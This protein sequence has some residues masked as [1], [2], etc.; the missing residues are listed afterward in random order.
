MFLYYINLVFVRI[1]SQ[2]IALS[3]GRPKSKVLKVE[4][5]ST[6]LGGLGHNARTI[7]LEVSYYSRGLYWYEQVSQLLLQLQRFILDLFSYRVFHIWH[8]QL[9]GQMV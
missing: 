4:F 3:L 1:L 8:N 9:T 7:H 5:S 2:N 6:I